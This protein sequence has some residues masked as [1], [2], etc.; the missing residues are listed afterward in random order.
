VETRLVEGRP[1]ATFI[2]QALL[3]PLRPGP[4]EITAYGFTFG[5]RPAGPLI[6]SGP[7]ILPGGQPTYTL[8]DSEPWNLAVRPLPE[9]GRP[10]HFNGAIGSFTMDPP[11]LSTNRLRT[12]DLLTMT[13][14]VRGEGNLDRLSPPPI[15]ASPE[16]QILA[17]KREAVLPAII[18]QRGFTP[19]E[20]RLIPLSEE[21]SR[22]PAIPFC[23]FNPSTGVYED[24]SVPAIDIQ[25]APGSTTPVRVGT[26]SLTEARTA[27]L[28]WSQ[29]E[30]PPTSL[31][32]DLTNRGR[33]ASTLAPLHHQAGF[34]ALQ[35]VPAALLAGL[36]M[37][38]KR[39]RYL[40][41]HPEVVLRRKARRAVRRHAHAAR[42]AARRGDREAFLRSA[43][44]GL[45]EAC[46]PAKPADPH[47]LA[48]CDVVPELASDSEAG[49]ELAQRLFDEAN[50]RQ[51]GPR[52]AAKDDLLALAPAV[53]E[54]LDHLRRKL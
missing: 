3:T 54:T 28:K 34:V 44:E 19:F 26:G 13:V 41:Q 4:I 12:G 38:D 36:W 15:P 43:I 22:T 48:G 24:L 49:R 39:R 32:R 40:E 5:G 21:I 6:I 30:A 18:R 42:R 9:T 46:A 14:V 23:T 47:A 17:P 35:L 37:W 10:A 25:V 20:Y 1:T 31:G 52:Q 29:R 8:V 2:Y 53:E 33:T 50:T 11:V 27:L 45:R 51:F 7:A 16:W